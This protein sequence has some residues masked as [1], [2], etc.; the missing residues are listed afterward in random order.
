M[1]TITL[2]QKSTGGKCT[3]T[4]SMPMTPLQADRAIR[5]FLE[6]KGCDVAAALPDLTAQVEVR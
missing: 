6:A 5:L 3:L 1:T 4:Y 2:T